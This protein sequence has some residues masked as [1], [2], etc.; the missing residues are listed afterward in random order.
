[1]PIGSLALGWVGRTTIRDY[2]LSVP[3]R[4]GEKRA[5]GYRLQPLRG[6]FGAD[7]WAKIRVTVAP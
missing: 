6:K 7:T 3:N 2:K 4:C 5:L 1:M